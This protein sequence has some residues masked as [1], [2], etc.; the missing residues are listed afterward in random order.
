VPEF[1][2]RATDRM[3][4]IVEGL[5]EAPV[6]RDVI[7]KL[8]SMGYIPIKVGH[9]GKTRSFSLD[10]DIA[11]FFK[12]IS[13]KDVMTFTQQL[14]TLI[15][16]S[17]PLD[18]S[19]SI[20]A[21]LTEKGE[22]QKVINEVLSSI[23]GGVTFA[24]A[25]AKHPKVF[26]KL[27]VNMIKAGEA[28][29]VLEMILERL[30]DFLE[31]SQELKETVTSAMLYPILLS[32]FCVLIVVLFLTVIIPMFSAMFEDAGDKVPASAQF[33]LGLSAAIKG[34]W[35]VIAGVIGGTCFGIKRYL[36]T[37]QGKLKWD[38]LKLKI[39]MIKTL[40]Q[41]IEVAR[42]ARTLGTL[43]RSGVP[44]L[45]ALNIV[46]ETISNLVIAGSLVG[47]HEGIKEG[48]GISKPLK[49]AGT[50]PPLAIHMITVGEETG[51]LDEML[52]KVADTYDKDVRTAVKQFV[53]ILEPLLILFMAFVVGSI[54][55]TMILAIISVNDIAF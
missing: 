1:A 13:S 21:E 44:I 39:F 5:M 3:G 23:Q 54:V 53:S 10:I 4:K 28:G 36:A 12:R 20:V 33:L 40:V 48:E 51:R 50:F 45:Q 42:F 35:W 49:S 41:K 17:L 38:E 52:L 16:A 27:Y 2:Y 31:G 15:S 19:L 29:G 30:V 46:K 6:E 18:K 34:Y 8:Q 37:E 32:G 14:S 11:G 9:P 47:I 24:D 25:L 43:I 7:G 26:S 22:F 55:V